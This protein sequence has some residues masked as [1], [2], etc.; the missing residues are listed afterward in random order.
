MP[1]EVILM[2]EELFLIS[3]SFEVMDILESVN[4]MVEFSSLIS[5]PEESKI[6]VRGFFTAGDFTSRVRPLDSSSIR[7]NDSVLKILI[8]SSGWIGRDLTVSPKAAAPDGVIR[9]SALK[10]HPD[11]RPYRG[12]DEE[13]HTFA[14]VRDGWHGPAVVV[15][16]QD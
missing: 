16:S 5:T 8:F 9:V 6:I 1:L 14:C 11:V 13:A 2:L 10:L 4:L 12:Q 7:E 15:L 3:T